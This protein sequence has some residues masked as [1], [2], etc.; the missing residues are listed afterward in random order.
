MLLTF[1]HLTCKTFRM[2]DFRKPKQRYRLLHFCTYI[3]CLVCCSIAAGRFLAADLGFA[4]KICHF[5]KLRV[6]L[7]RT[8]QSLPRFRKKIQMNVHQSERRCQLIY[9]AQCSFS[10]YDNRCFHFFS[11]NESTY[12]ASIFSNFFDI[13][14]FR[15]EEQNLFTVCNNFAK[16]SRQDSGQP[17]VQ[18]V[19]QV[20][21]P[22]TSL[23]RTQSTLRGRVWH[24]SSFAFG[25]VWLP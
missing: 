2:P 7:K 15:A 4:S 1:S 10:S 12:T 13:P 24:H 18:Q 8:L 16:L 19:S 5:Y 3:H 9:Y 6:I 23:I 25:F 22:W 11:I 14:I 21:E 20:S 17:S